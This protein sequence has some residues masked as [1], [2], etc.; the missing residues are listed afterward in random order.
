MARERNG[1]RKRRDKL[2]KRVPDLGY[3]Y[4]VTDTE[5][6]EKNY[7]E[8]LKKALPPELQERIVIH[9]SKA[10]TGQLIAACEQADVDPQYRQC[11]IVF[12]RD[13]VVSFDEIIEEALSKNIKI[14]WSNPCIEIWFSAYFGNMPAVRDS[15]A[16]CRTFARLFERVTGQKYEKSNPQIY[17][18]LNKYG[19]EAAAIHKAEKRLNSHFWNGETRPSQMCPGTTLHH[20]IYEIRSKVS[21]QNT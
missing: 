17:T 2:P 13:Q 4:I 9:V 12:D 3:Y 10:R 19:N 6:T 1:D 16:C 8:G 21:L 14:G 7:L 5:E 11:W 18:V 15:V 20:L